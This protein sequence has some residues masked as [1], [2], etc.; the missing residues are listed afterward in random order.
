MPEEARRA[1]VV[2]GER[3]PVLEAGDAAAGGVELVGRPRA[4]RR[5]PGD[6]EREQDEEDE[7]DDGDRVRLARCEGGYDHGERLQLADRRLVDAVRP[8][9]VRPREHPGREDHDDAERHPDAQPVDDLLPEE[10]RSERD[11]AG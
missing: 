4:P 2:A 11:Q 8:A 6:P 7:E 1:H 10:A 9:D 3:E 5:P